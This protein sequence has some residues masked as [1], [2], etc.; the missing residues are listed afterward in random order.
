MNKI[1]FAANLS[2]VR[3]MLFHCTTQ[4]VHEHVVFVGHHSTRNTVM[5]IVRRE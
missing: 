1:P 3:R 2:S 4:T 5:L